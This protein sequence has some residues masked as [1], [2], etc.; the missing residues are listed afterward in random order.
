MTLALALSIAFLSA[1]LLFVTWLLGTQIT[2]P[3]VAVTSLLTGAASVVGTF[4]LVFWRMNDVYRKQWYY[5][6]ELYNEMLKHDEER[7]ASLLANSL[8]MDLIVVDLWAHRSFRELFREEFW[9]ALQLKY[10]REPGTLSDKVQRVEKRE[11]GEDEALCLLE[12]YQEQLLSDHSHRKHKSTPPKERREG[13]R[14]GG[15][16]R[17]KES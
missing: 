11:F 6:Q 16:A 9:E 17:P 1:L 15:R 14:P 12:W 13:P 4:S 2:T 8:A 3:Q 5:C 10:E 7:T